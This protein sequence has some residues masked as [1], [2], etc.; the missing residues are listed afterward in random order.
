MFSKIQTGLKNSKSRISPHKNN[1]EQESHSIKTKTPSPDGSNTD[2]Q[3]VEVAVGTPPEETTR[4]MEMAKGTSQDNENKYTAPTNTTA[5]A[6]KGI[7]KRTNEEQSASNQQSSVEESSLMTSLDKTKPVTSCHVLS[8]ND[9][10]LEISELD[11]YEQPFASLTDEEK[12]IIGLTALPSSGDSHDG[13]FVAVKSTDSKHS[14]ASNHSSHSVSQIDSSVVRKLFDNETEDKAVAKINQIDVNAAESNIVKEARVEKIKT[15]SLNKRLKAKGVEKTDEKQ[16]VCE[17]DVTD[18][19]QEHT[20][21]KEKSVI[22]GE[23]PRKRKSVQLQISVEGG[24]DKKQLLDI[25]AKKRKSQQLPCVTSSPN[26]CSAFKNEDGGKAIKRNESHTHTEATLHA[27][28]LSASK[29]LEHTVNSRKSILGDSSEDVKKHKAVSDSPVKLKN[30]LPDKQLT[31]ENAHA[32]KKKRSLSETEINFFGSAKKTIKT[33]K[34]EKQ[35]KSKD[36]VAP[37]KTLKPQKIEKRGSEK[38]KSLQKAALLTTANITISSDDSDM[39]SA[40]D[41]DSSQEEDDSLKRIWDDFELPQNDIVMEKDLTSPIKNQTQES[42]RKRTLPS[43]SKDSEM[44][45]Q[46]SMADA[47]GLGKKQRVAHTS[48]HVS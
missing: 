3:Q 40:A 4:K 15:Y 41:W 48:S 29:S 11:D 26:N 25:T 24:E 32:P 47:L 8:S 20:V 17:S 37:V 23:K 18:K 28:F 33:E 6:I 34:L 12:K 14:S 1:T 39:C 30:K 19:K 22:T 36:K 42:P 45:K 13:D 16:V 44:D 38:K 43:V 5:S 7:L 21:G 10:S 9:D 27:L 46:P 31:T 2:K 35:K